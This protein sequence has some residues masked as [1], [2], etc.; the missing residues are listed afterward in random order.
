MNLHSSMRVRG[1]VVIDLVRDNEIRHFEMKNLTV[2]GGYNVLTKMI[3]DTAQDSD[4]LA[5]IAVGTGGHEIGHIEN[6]LPPKPTDTQLETEVGRSPIYQFLTPEI[7][8]LQFRA[9]IDANLAIDSDITEA[10]LL[11]ENGTLFARVTFPAI[12]KG[13]GYYLIITWTITLSEK[14]T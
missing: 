12:H 4:Q 3:L 7:T 6:P 14:V 8:E 13:S 11:T 2:N 1:H 9:T 5:Y 10:G